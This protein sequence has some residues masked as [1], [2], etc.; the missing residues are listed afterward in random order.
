MV[1]ATWQARAG[2][3]LVVA[4]L[5]L[6]GVSVAEAHALLLRAEPGAGA[7]VPSDARP[8]RVSLW[9]SEPVTVALSGIAVLEG[10]DVGCYW[11]K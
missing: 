5:A 2:V 1:V 6:A 11:T 10:W 4:W 3:M 9:F 8:G 7:V